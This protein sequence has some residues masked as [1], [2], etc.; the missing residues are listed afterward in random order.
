MSGPGPSPK[1]VDS[2]IVKDIG[3]RD[4][5]SIAKLLSPNINVIVEDTDKSGTGSVAS[6]LSPDI[7]AQVMASTDYLVHQA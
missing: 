6:R 7:V 3:D 5:D 4:T 2:T 1:K